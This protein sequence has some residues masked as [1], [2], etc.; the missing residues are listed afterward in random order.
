[1]KTRNVKEA[2]SVTLRHWLMDHPILKLIALLLAV[3]VWF[4]VSGEMVKVR[5]F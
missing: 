4:Y 5:Y 1:M 2:F 3:I